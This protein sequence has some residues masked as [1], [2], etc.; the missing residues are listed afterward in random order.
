M[1]KV[2]LPNIFDKI[3]PVLEYEVACY[4]DTVD[5]LKIDI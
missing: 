1:N 4:K 2:L 5:L 3:L